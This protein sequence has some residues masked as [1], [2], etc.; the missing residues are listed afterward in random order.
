MAKDI[1]EAKKVSSQ[2]LINETMKYVKE[3]HRYHSEKDFDKA[4]RKTFNELEAEYLILKG[5]C[6]TSELERE[7]L[8][9]I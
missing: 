7:I 9:K 4:H 6:K 2:I 3:N 1:D 5:Y 8:E